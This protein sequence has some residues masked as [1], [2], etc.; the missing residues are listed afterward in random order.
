MLREENGER[1]ENKI[2][3]ALISLFRVNRRRTSAA[4]SCFNATGIIYYH[5]INDLRNSSELIP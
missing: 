1:T 3:P 5:R 4:P 2:L